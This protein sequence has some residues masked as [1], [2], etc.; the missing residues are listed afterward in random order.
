[1]HYV[2]AHRKE[3]DRQ[4]ID[5]DLGTTSQVIG[6]IAPTH[7]CYAQWIPLSDVIRK[8]VAVMVGSFATRSIHR[9]PMSRIVHVT[10]PLQF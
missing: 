5:E 4:A 7:K 2:V 10:S 6:E 1:M 3:L 9:G 8:L